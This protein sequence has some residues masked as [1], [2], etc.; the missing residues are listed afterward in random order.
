MPAMS[1]EEVRDDRSL[2][3]HYNR[4][5][6]LA[7]T[8]GP[9]PPEPKGLF[10]RN[11]SLAIILLDLLLI[12]LIFVLFQFVFTPGRSAA[13]VGD[14]DLELSAFRFEDELYVTVEIT[15][16]RNREEIPSGD[17]QLVTVEVPGVEPVLDALPVS[18]SQSIRVTAVTTSSDSDVVVDV[19]LF[20][21]T[22]T[23]RAQP[24]R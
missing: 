17:D 8:G 14:Y 1:R 9:T 12:L 18:Q 22:V 5:E 20:G 6:R 4:E 13:R 7:Q 2:H 23:I 24:S 10:R 21:E 16:S 19:T 15:R 3:F 11:R